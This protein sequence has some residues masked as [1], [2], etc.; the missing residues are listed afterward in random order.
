MSFYGLVGQGPLVFAPDLPPPGA[1]VYALG[2]D[3]VGVY[4]SIDGGLTW[5]EL[6]GH[7]LT[8]GTTMDVLSVPGGNDV[9][10]ALDSNSTGVVKSLDGGVTWTTC[11]FPGAGTI[12]ASISIVDA[13]TVYLAA[14]DGI[15]K[16]TDGG[17]TWS[18]WGTGTDYPYLS[19]AKGGAKVWVSSI[20]SFSSPEKYR[21]NADH[22]GKETFNHTVSMDTPRAVSD[23]LAFIVT[24]L[25]D[26]VDT[27]LKIS[28]STITNITPAASDPYSWI[29]AWS[30]DGGMTIIARLNGGTCAI[31]KSI[32]GGG[33]WAL[34]AIDSTLIVNANF[35]GPWLAVDP[36]DATKWWAIGQAVSDVESTV[37]Y[38]TDAGDTWTP[39]VVAVGQIQLRSVCAASG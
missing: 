13:D 35:N 8:A 9:I 31:Y 28:G 12:P 24:G 39:V 14:S 36:N 7:G 22:T 16:T 19:A 30:A 17:S 34:V 18:T 25:G 1:R 38:S 3:P 2:G 5:T 11:T 27:L 37:W 29:D 26:T 6:T 33:A 4:K 21:Y 10:Y 15:K 23:T 20:I 32:N